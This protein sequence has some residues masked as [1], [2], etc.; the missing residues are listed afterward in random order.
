MHV[1]LNPYGLAYTFGLQAT[2]SLRDNPSPGGL[3]QFITA[4]RRIGARS[5]EID[6]RWL[7]QVPDE[8]L[9]ALGVDLAASGMTVVVSTWLQHR[10]G[11][12]LADA[13][14]AARLLGA[15]LVR[16]HLLPILEGAR[17]ALG[18]DWRR[19]FDHA[20][21]VLI[22]EAAA[23]HDD[24][25]TLGIE[26]HQDLGSEE[27]LALAA[28]A[29]DNVGIVFDT[30]NPFAVGEDPVAFARRVIH[31]L[32]HVHLKDYR[33]QMTAA[34]Y[35]LIRCAVGDGCVPFDEIVD[36]IAGTHLDRPL[37][38]SIELAALE[39]RHI[40]LFTPEWWQGYPPREARELAT[41]IGRLQLS[42]LGEDADWRTPWELRAQPAAIVAYEQEQLDRSVAFVREKGWM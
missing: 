3:D 9:V 16:L 33:A 42:R 35:R 20:R 15:S 24:R 5:I 23:A 19:R 36:V 13:R 21:R 2:G 34:G 8:Q 27:L 28:E 6:W 30:G 22:R 4:A 29:G 14:R 7:L 17:S 32:V 18:P 37:T 40:R 10:E 39:A 25:L 11:E 1:G 26:D 31:R 38:A 41:A 12:T